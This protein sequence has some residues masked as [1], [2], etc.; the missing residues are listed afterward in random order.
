[1]PQK[2]KITLLSALVCGAVAAGCSRGEAFER[3]PLVR[4]DRA[5]ASGAELD[6]VMQAGWAD[7]ASVA[8]A[9]SPGEYAATEAVAVFQP[10]VESRL[11]ALDS[12]E[13]V[14]GR[15]RAVMSESLPEVGWRTTYAV[16]WPYSQSVV[17]GYDGNVL[18]ALNHYLGADYPGYQ[19]RFPAYLSRLKSVERL[20]VDV[21]EMLVD[22]NYG[23]V[24]G[25]E[26]TPALI[27]RMLH[28]G[29]VLYT[30]AQLLPPD[31]PLWTLL[32]VSAEQAGWLEDNEAAM[33]RRM[34]EAGMVYAS[35]PQLAD[36]LLARAPVSAAISADA[37]GGAAG[38]IGLRIVEAY[39][40]SKGLGPGVHPELLTPQFYN[41]MQ[42]L[43]DSEYAPR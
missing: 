15:V 8:G 29:A 11:P 24:A 12:V 17:Y 41:S 10:D 38:F 36:R 7:L 19:G 2:L 1:M 35:D 14:L 3:E 43:I 37:P 20:P 31:T 18:V 30:M 21:A 27:N 40:R 34:M 22:G 4:L 33:W 39:V 16:V 32:G 6:S 25:P 5:I 9:G 42:S 23:Y 28:R 13:H 26:F